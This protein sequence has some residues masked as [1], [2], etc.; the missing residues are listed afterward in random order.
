MSTDERT[1]ILEYWFRTLIGS[2]ISFSDISSIIVEFANEYEMF[3]PALCDM[4]GI[5]IENDGKIL[6][7]I[8]S[9]QDWDDANAFGSFVAAPGK[10]YNWK[11]K[12]LPVEGKSI[13]YTNIGII[14]ANA[15]SESLHSSWFVHENGYSYF[16]GTGEI[17]NNNTWW[18]YGD[19]YGKNDIIDICLDLKNKKELSFAKNGKTL[20]KAADIKHDMGFRLAIGMDV[21][22]Q[23]IELLS[24][25]ILK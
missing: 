5:K 14:E 23:K 3:E 16:A 1:L 4:E 10:I 7:K 15:A 12:V 11:L 19:R 9:E 18:D 17:Y 13:I 20:G 21:D 22:T 6:H 24:F 8:K 2:E 25:E